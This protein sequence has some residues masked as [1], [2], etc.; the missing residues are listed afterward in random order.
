M[1]TTTSQQLFEE[2]QQWQGQGNL[3][4]AWV[5][6]QN[7]LKKEPT[8]VPS[9]K[10]M[11]NILYQQKEYERAIEIFQ[12]LTAIQ[13]YNADFWYRKGMAHAKLEEDQ[14]IN[15]FRKVIKMHPATDVKAQQIA[16][17]QLAKALKRAG[18]K[19]EV[20]KIAKQLV[21][22]NPKNASALS[23][24]GEMAQKEKE[25]EK[26]YSYFQ[27]VIQLVPNNAAAQL[28]I[29]TTYFFK[30]EMEKAIIHF[31][32]S[33]TLDPNLIQAYRE[34]A[35]CHHHLG[36]TKQTLNLLEKALQLAP[37]DIENYRYFVDYYQ[38][39]GDPKES[40]GYAQKLLELAPED[41][42]TLYTVGQIYGVLGAVEAS[43]PYV[44]KA[45]G[46]EADA[47]AA[48]AIGNAYNVL[49]DKAQAREWFEKTLEHDADHFTARYNL[50]FQK[51]EQC[52]W[53]DRK[54]DEAELIHALEAHIASEKFNLSIPA[55]LFNYFELPMSL[56]LAMNAYLAKSK[57]ETTN[58]LKKQVQFNHQKTKKKK[59]HIAYVSPDFRDHP[60]GRLVANIFQYHNRQEVKV[61][62]YFLTPYDPKDPYSKQIASDSDVFRDFAYT[63]S[64]GVAQQIYEDQIDVLI[65]LAGHTANNRMDILA[66]QPAPIQA[67]LI[68]YPN[69]TGQ[70]FIQ[71]YLGDPYLTPNS[72]Q[73]YYSE[74]IW[75]LPSAFVGEKPIIANQPF[76][77]RE[78]GLPEDAF[79][80]VGF[81]RPSKIEPELFQAWMN[82]LNG[83]ENSVLWLSDFSATARQNL[84]GFAAKQ[85]ISAD[86]LI[87]SPRRPYDL[88]LKSY[89]LADL[90]LDTWHYSAGSTAVAALSAG[91]PVL[92][93]MADNNAARMGAC[94]VAAAGLPELI[95]EDL[96]EYE[97]KAI[98]IA[99]NRAVLEQY[100]A[101][102][103]QPADQILLFNHQQFAQNLET[104]FWKMYAET[105]FDKA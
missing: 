94:I 8:H 93:C 41:R 101:H 71:Y 3:P 35:M 38:T 53:Q 62:A 24:L 75:Q 21:K 30:K 95:C 100:K 88:Y 84:I 87:F 33:L 60:V 86:R 47:Q 66:L 89:Q 78:A 64:I 11:A 77:R 63:S 13:P 52:D 40:L 7:I 15:C 83:V 105:D 22:Q 27:K 81:N 70:D 49:K 43:L 39:Q 10:S 50:I 103:A 51:M 69:T 4:K 9:L 29:G 34:L 104:A 102:L 23:L 32:K 96:K 57:V 59:L 97:Q 58:L 48:Y 18:K 65:D 54:V 80:F 85:D 45:Y 76:S 56:H 68:G 28:N 98:G 16:H 5:C 17:L 61:F 99:H 1:S 90:F 37:K 46:I 72:L 74:K 67:H 42:A 44:K 79:V 6:Y 36:Q 19:E 25:I 73:A 82:I 91:L 92:T 2:A 14:A 20:K 26:A 12:S 31:Q 55:L